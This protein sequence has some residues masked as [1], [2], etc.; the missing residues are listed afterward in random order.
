MS[1]KIIIAIDGPAG[2]GKSTT[3][4]AV[5]ERLGYIYIDT[6]A[7]YRAVT[8]LAVSNGLE[9]DPE[10]VVSVLQ[11]TDF[12]LVLS[13]DGNLIHLDGVDVTPFLRTESVNNAVSN[14]S[15]IEAVRSELVK[16]Q[17]Q[18]GSRGGVV[19]EGRDIGTVVF[20]NADLKIFLTAS[21][22]ARTARRQREYAS[23]GNKITDD[24]VRQNLLYRDAIDS[25]R[26]VSPLQKAP[27]AV[28]LDT[29]EL[30]IDEQVSKIV[31]LAHIIVSRQEDIH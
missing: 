18:I 4:L 15:K 30:S 3:A 10:K 19:M 21:I 12:E 24:K 1:K 28:L 26:D 7:M 9:N 29:S 31:E 16:K 22:D 23:K 17:Q 20:P 13:P 6:G 11:G 25:S 14:I 8:Y 5:A 2:S 27:D